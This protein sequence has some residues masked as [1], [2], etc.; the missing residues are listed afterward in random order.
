MGA[1]GIPGIGEV[2]KRDA[3]FREEEMERK[4]REEDFVTLKCRCKTCGNT[5][6]LRVN[7]QWKS[8]NDTE[9]KQEIELDAK[10]PKCKSS[11]IEV[12]ER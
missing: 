5:F 7:P 12:L 4:F 1:H 6:S 9:E 11:E 3:V 8:G 2:G 10:C